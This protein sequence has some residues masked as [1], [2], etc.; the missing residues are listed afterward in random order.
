MTYSMRLLVSKSFTNL[1]VKVY[2]FGFWFFF[3]LVSLASSSSS[4]KMILMT[5]GSG[6]L[7]TATSFEEKSCATFPLRPCLV[8]SL[9]ASANWKILRLTRLIATLGVIAMSYSKIVFFGNFTGKK[10][11]LILKLGPTVPKSGLGGRS[12]GLIVICFM[13]A[14][15]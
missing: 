7:L 9:V 10:L 4:T 15:S 14:M 13:L 1:K 8:Q 5:N 11:V 3:S 12:D 2:S 6:S